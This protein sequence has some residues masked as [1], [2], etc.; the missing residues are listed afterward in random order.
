MSL[1][2]AI[3]LALSLGVLLL[4]PII[5][6]L[7][8][9]P[10]S[11][12]LHFGAMMLM[13]RLPLQLRRRKRV[14]DWL[15]L[16]LRLIALL[17]FVLAVTQ[18][19]L[20]W[21]QEDP[22][23][24][25]AK[26]VVLIIDDSLSMDQKIGTSLDGER[27]SAFRE[28]RS[29]AIDF[30]KSLPD[31]VELGIVTTA[32]DADLLTPELRAD[33]S[34]IMALVAERQQR[35][36]DTDLVGALRLARQVLDGKGGEVFVFSDESGEETIGAC[37]DEISL[38]ASQNV[39]L[40]PQR[41]RADKPQNV[42]VISA[43]YGEG[44][45]GGSLRFNIENFGSL[46]K[47]VTTITSFPDGTEINTFVS[48]APF[49][50]T[51]EL[52]TVPRI[53]EGG[54]GV[55]RITDDDLI[56]DNEFYF[57]LPQIG[58]SRV[59]LID[60]EPGATTS[61]SEIYYLERAIAPWGGTRGGSLPDVVG[62][63]GIGLLDPEVHRVVFMA[64]IGNPAA[65]APALISFVR[66]GGGLFLSLGD[67]VTSERYNSALSELLP[68]PLRKIEALSSPRVPGERTKLPNTEF[69]IFKPF[70]RGG[71]DNFNQV[72]WNRVFSVEPFESSEGNKVLL[73]LANGMP[74]LIEKKVGQGHVFLLT[75]TI[76]DEWGN[77]PLQGSFLPLIQ[78]SIPY[79]G[80]SSSMGG[81]RI[82]GVVDDLIRVPIGEMV[83]DLVVDGP[84][85]PVS[86]NNEASSLLFKPSIP[87]AYLVHSKGGP[88]IALISVNTSRSES[89]LA[90]PVGLMET[91]ST[92]EPEAFTKQIPLFSYFL[93]AVAVLLIFQAWL[94]YGPTQKED[95]DAL[96]A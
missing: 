56:L 29:Q 78:R 85:G 82:E 75:S 50:V 33:R 94:S 68:A 10:P 5:A 84:N 32:G 71:L 57:Q 51:E 6:H 27:E 19:I 2:W 3:P 17:L 46:E 12:R 41:I 21:P 25:Q 55:I 91:A 42:S 74:L 66:N 23:I 30:V 28:A 53:S 40:F 76:D 24:D 86:S 44:V 63:T 49:S 48:I 95:I 37:A 9:Q 31:G 88:P 83:T 81:L 79:L 34:E 58:A 45:E 38:M 15:L 43:E 8:R 7:F 47:E 64:N 52:V 35:F 59:L 96:I 77:L 93:W 11:K 26:R 89:V 65:L 14:Q 18:P 16:L 39:G 80:G 20:K 67:N 73:E 22:E 90:S 54:V 72:R 92:L 1:S 87:G 70:Q 4:G 36:G 62:E 60:G 13:L 69:S 61:D